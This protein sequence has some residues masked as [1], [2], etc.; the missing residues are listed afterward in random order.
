MSID[1]K[2]PKKIFVLRHKDTEKYLNYKNVLVKNFCRALIFTSEWK[3]RQRRSSL[4]KI[5]SCCLEIVEYFLSQNC[6]K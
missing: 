4:K 3:A 2:Y 1:F 5:D 6:I